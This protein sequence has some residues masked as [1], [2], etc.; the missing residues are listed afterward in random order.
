MPTTVGSLVLFVA[1]LT[2]GFVYLTRAE[3][4]LPRQKYTALRETAKVVSASLF[5]DS[6]VLGLFGAVRTAVPRLTPDVGALVRTPADYF[7]EH[8]LEVVSWGAGLLAL[9]VGLA[10]VCAVP[11]RWT[12]HLLK[13]LDLNPL[14][15]LVSSI[16]R[17]RQSPI[18]HESGWGT[19]FLRYPECTIYVGLDLV[20][21]SYV[22]GELGEFNSQLEE[23]SDRSLQL[24]GPVEIRSSAPEADS[25]ASLDVSS[26]I[27]SANQIKTIAVHYEG[28]DIE[29]EDDT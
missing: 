15:N 4:R 28:S 13:W 17:R 14:Y 19:A 22:Y 9:A 1:L 12:L 7:K 3:T 27:V 11:P 8:Y 26:L 25:M 5:V 21:G 23:T 10:A 24:L 2:P 16:E 6:I 20:D 18:I 29:E